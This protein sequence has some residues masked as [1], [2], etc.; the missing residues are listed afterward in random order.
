MSAWIFQANPTTYDL[1]SALRD[2]HK[3]TWSVRQHRAEIQAG[4]TAYLWLAGPAGG[5][6]GVASILTDPATMAMDPDELR[7]AAANSDLLGEETRVRIEI[8]RVLDPPLNRARVLQWP[9]LAS[10]QL[11]RQAQGTNF[12]VT[13]DEAANL[14][15]LIEAEPRQRTPSHFILITSPLYPDSW[16][17]CNRGSAAGA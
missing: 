15:Q 1:R 13:G 7:Y 10:L 5:L 11:F 6:A 12:P 17:R 4:D 3:Q 2:L 9:G 16:G 14:E 8:G